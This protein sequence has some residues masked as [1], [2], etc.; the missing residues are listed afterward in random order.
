VNTKE[1]IIGVAVIL[2]M[3]LAAT[4]IAR[5]FEAVFAIV[6]VLAIVYLFVE[7]EVITLE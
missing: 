7:Q 4:A 6:I 1:K 3:T 2:L 5:G